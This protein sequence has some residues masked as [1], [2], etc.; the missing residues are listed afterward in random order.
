M[1]GKTS[2]K[3]S[4]NFLEGSS[5][6]LTATARTG[7]DFVGWYYDEACTKSYSKEN[8]IELNNIQE[9][10]SYYAQF[11]IKTFTVKAVAKQADGADVGTVEFTAPEAVAPGTSVTVTV[12]YGGSATFVAKPS[13]DGY[14]FVA[15]TD[16]E[17]N[18]IDLNSEYTR[19]NIKNSF[20][21]LFDICIVQNDIY[22]KSLYSKSAIL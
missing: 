11:K 4:Q 18:Q 3:V 14:K 19:K 6:S 17:G 8:V 9:N 22:L 1:E 12:N 5:T 7:Y 16:A 2:N 13:K 21:S 15:W 20:Y 10:H